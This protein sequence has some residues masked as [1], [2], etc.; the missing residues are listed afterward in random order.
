MYYKWKMKKLNNVKIHQNV[1]RKEKIILE[2][3]IMTLNN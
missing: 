1:K 2:Y 3:N